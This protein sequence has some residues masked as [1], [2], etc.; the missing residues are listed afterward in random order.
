[1]WM[2]F[3]EKVEWQEKTK[4]EWYLAKIIQVLRAHTKP[5]E[6]IY[7]EDCFLDFS[8][9]QKPT[10]E[11]VEKKKQADLTNAKLYWCAI[12]GLETAEVFK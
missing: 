6:I 2:E 1:M 11:E 4:L 12:T 7:L 5:G 10:P 9:P 3:L 8:L